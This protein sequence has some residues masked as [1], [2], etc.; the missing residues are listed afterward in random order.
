M[1]LPHWRS[2]VYA[3]QIYTVSSG[4]NGAAGI[5][6]S[7]FSAMRCNLQHAL[8]S[9]SALMQLHSVSIGKVE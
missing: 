2:V 9:Q 3:I 7:A 4:E 8:G 1:D 6:D 5:N